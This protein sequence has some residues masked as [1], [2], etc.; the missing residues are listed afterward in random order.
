MSWSQKACCKDGDCK[1]DE[2]SLFAALSGPI[3]LHKLPS[4][5]RTNR[6][7]LRPMSS[8]QFQGS[9]IRLKENPSRTVCFTYWI[10]GWDKKSHLS[11]KFL[12]ELNSG[13]C[14]KYLKRI[15]FSV[16]IIVKF[17][18]GTII[19]WWKDGEFLYFVHKL[20]HYWIFDEILEMSKSEHAATIVGGIYAF[21]YGTYS[22]RRLCLS[23]VCACLA[24]K[25][26]YVRSFILFVRKGH[27]A[28]S[29]KFKT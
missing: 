8:V 22:R 27:K 7:L 12:N 13:S 9:M 17:N 26:V 1:T 19:R 20:F 18:M 2:S 5:A 25:D 10:I 4:A 24:V 23:H 11:C 29:L 16:L 14:L 6:E 21:M 15:I 28:I 3:R